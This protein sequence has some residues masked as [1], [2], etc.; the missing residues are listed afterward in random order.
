M[1]D[2]FKPTKRVLFL[3]DRIGRGMY[4]GCKWTTGTRFVRRYHDLTAGHYSGIRTASERE[5]VHMLTFNMIEEVRTPGNHDTYDTTDRE[6]PK[7][8]AEGYKLVLTDLGRRL[9]K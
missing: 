9:R 4:S 3:L 8:V 6:R 1:S 2:P 5:I 7:L